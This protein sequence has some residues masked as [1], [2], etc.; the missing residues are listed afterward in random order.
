MLKKIL[1]G[2]AMAS[3]FLLKKE[4]FSNENI[5]LKP[6]DMENIDK[7]QKERAEATKKRLKKEALE[8]MKK[9]K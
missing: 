5:K 4:M 9:E 6:E 2:I 3:P 8:K 7:K 1:A